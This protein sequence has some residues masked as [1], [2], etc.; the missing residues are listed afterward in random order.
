MLDAK[1]VLVGKFE[2]DLTIDALIASIDILGDRLIGLI[3]NDVQRGHLHHIQTAV[4]PYLERRG[5]RVLGIMPRDT[6]LRSVSVAE[7]AETLHAKVLSGQD[8]L[9]EFVEHFS[10]GAMNVESALRH[11]RRTS[12][13]AVIT[14]GDRSDIQL[15]A[16]ET[17]TKCIVLTGDLYPNS[18]ILAR[19]E[20]LDVPMLIVPDDTLAT[21]E[22]IERLLGRS[23][24]REPRKIERAIGLV[25]EH[26]DVAA[27][28]AAL[29]LSAKK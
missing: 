15:V 27:I 1:A 12:N 13:K 20:E 24:V 29:R 19:A 23:R 14:G 21:V 28:L 26:V 11:F 3:I 2:S 5:V 10:V 16:L 25:E 4:Q 17:S 18:L 6:I 7:L 22:R 9:D 8:H